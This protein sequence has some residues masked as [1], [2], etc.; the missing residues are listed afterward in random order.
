MHI[1]I[2]S[3]LT[4]LAG[5]TIA[6]LVLP[7]A[8]QRADLGSPSRH[9]I[10]DH[11]CPSAERPAG[12]RGWY[13]LVSQDGT[14]CPSHGEKQWTGTI[15][16]TDTRR[17]FF[18]AFESRND[19]VNDPFIFWMHGG[20]G[21][22]SMTGAFTQ[23]GPCMLRNDN[24]IP[25]PN[26]WSW[27]NNANL[28]FLDQPAGVGFSSVARGGTPPAKDMDGAEDFQVFLNIFFRDVFPRKAHLPIHIATESYGGHYGPTYV[29]HILASRQRDAPT[30]F[31]GNITS[32]I[33]VDAMIDLGG[34]IT[35]F[36]ELLCKDKRGAEILTEEECV[37]ML[38]ALPSHEILASQCEQTLDIEKCAAVP[39]YASENITAYYGALVEKGERSPYH[40]YYP[41]LDLPDC[42]HPEMDNLT[43]YLNRREVKRKLGFP[44]CFTFYETNKGLGSAYVKS[45]FAWVP[46]THK[47]AAI[48]DAYKTPKLLLDGTRFGDVRIMVLNGNLDP[49][50]NTHGNIAQYDRIIWSRRD[51]YRIA[52]WQALNKEEVKAS[53]SWKGTKDG[54]LVFVAIDDAGGMV[55]ADAP[56]A[57]YHILDRWLR[58][59]WR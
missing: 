8:P 57:S 50:V 7:F 44:D 28:V 29:Q 56:E 33:L 24:D 13:T 2:I 9:P 27:N 31:W 38:D 12:K 40:L 30:A 10:N 45:G 35:G 43:E 58:N 51:E 36:H 4:A 21:D 11:D 32:M 19:P 1:S 34:L 55:P 46:T 17:L 18:W 59:E 52:T 14:V 25:K 54:R 48:L 20:P 15:D 5:S 49:F 47:V 26:P 37:K 42:H 16:V 23:L 39:A 41:C 22:S 3:L 53:G 6:Q